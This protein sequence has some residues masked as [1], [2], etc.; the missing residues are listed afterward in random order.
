MGRVHLVAPSTRRVDSEL[1][2]TVAPGHSGLGHKVGRIVRV[3]DGEGAGHGLCRVRLCQRAG[4][5]TSDHRR[6]VGACN[7]HFEG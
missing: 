1:A 5:V 2:V 4:G 7:L 3:G 6:V